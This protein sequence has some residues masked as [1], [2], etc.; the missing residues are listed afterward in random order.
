MDS[1]DGLVKLKAP[2]AD[3][4]YLLAGSPRDRSIIGALQATGGIWEPYL[5]NVMKACIADDSVCLDIGANIGAMTLVMSDLTS[6]GSVFAFEPSSRNA[7]FLRANLAR[8]NASNVTI[9]QTAL[10]D[11]TSQIE[12]FYV[13]E[14]AACSFLDDAGHRTGLDK[15]KT[16]VSQEWVQQVELHCEREKVEC[17]RL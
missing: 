12:L 3:H 1:L 10:L 9:F 7:S 5:M 17:I 15:I 13:D 6:R 14:L 11:C 2:F 16:V 4:C 8:N